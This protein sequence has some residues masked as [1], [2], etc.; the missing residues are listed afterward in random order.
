MIL[1]RLAMAPFYNRRTMTVTS[2]ASAFDARGA[3][4]LDRAAWRALLVAACGWLFDGYET[5]ALILVGALAIRELVPPD[6]LAQLPIYF[7]GLVAITLVGWATGGLVGGVLADYLGRRR[8]LML[9]VL[10]YAVFTGLSALAQTYWMLLVFRFL[11][12]L[13]LGGEFS[14]GAA[15]VAELWPPGRRGR[16]AGVLASAFGVGSLLAAGLWFLVGSVGHGSWR[17]MFVIGILPA[18]V[19][20]WMRRGVVDPAVWVA[21]DRRRQEARQAAQAGHALSEAERRLT[22]FTVLDLF[23]SDELRKRTLL[24]LIMA[25]STIVG[26]WAVSTWIP[27]YATQVATQAGLGPGGWGARAGLLY[28]AGG[29]VGY[30]TLGVMADAWGR[31]RSIGFFFAGS[32]VAGAAP[33]LVQTNFPLF[34]TVV[35]VNG[36]FTTGQFAWLAMY[37]PEVYPTAVRGTGTA[38][39]FNSARYVA[40][41]GP[42]AAGW[43]VESLG[44]IAQAAVLM[45]AIY[46]LG[47]SVTP[48]AAPETRGRPLPD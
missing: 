44:G 2:A 23:A 28:S 22:R 13:G 33:F 8:M 31:K 27:Q 5:Y 40:A 17:H 15:L 41:L 39:V 46:L 20:F 36:F 7:G 37:P 48:F 30:L 29:I 9:S 10:C 24:L 45:T 42:L 19:L 16:A 12:G 14:P 3:R 43:L 18:L 47:L 4:P 26:Y 21:A 6:H 35:A 25:L 11:T 38:V 34:L 32:L 1:P